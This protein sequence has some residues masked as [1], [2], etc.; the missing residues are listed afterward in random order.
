MHRLRVDIEMFKR[1]D[2]ILKEEPDEY[3]KCE[4]YED[5]EGSSV[6]T[7][8]HIHKDSVKSERDSYQK[9]FGKPL[10]YHK[11][12]KDRGNIQQSQCKYLKLVTFL[13][14]M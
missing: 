2:E 6:D 7:E 8:L 11:K 3:L 13:V 14:K 5:A 9:D 4:I 1:V 12:E 10:E